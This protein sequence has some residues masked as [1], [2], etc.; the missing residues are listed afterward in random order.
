MSGGKP[1]A[2]GEKA[3]HKG[4]GQ[5]HADGPNQRGPMGHS[6]GLL[7]CEGLIAATPI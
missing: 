7:V 6:R 2:H 1:Q 5:A 4:D 3:R